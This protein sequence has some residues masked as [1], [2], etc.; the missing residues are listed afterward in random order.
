MPTA[1]PLRIAYLEDEAQNAETVGAWL[2]EAGYAVD[3]F[4]RGADCARAVERS[5]YDACLL[6]WMVPDMSGPE[7]LARIRLQLKERPPPVIFLTGRDSEEDLVAMLAAGADDYI[8]KPASRAVLLARVS[9]VLR[10]SGVALETRR[11]VW[12]ELELDFGLRRIFFQG[13]HIVLTERETDLALY[14]LQNTGRLLTRAHLLQTVWAH[15]AEVESR[16][17]DMHAST[18]RRKLH[19]SPQHGWQLVSIYGQGYRL[20]WLGATP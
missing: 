13:Q 14:L 1:L 9:A 8:V 20:E 10:R 18:L 2:R 7:V 17:V 15:S 5:L 19:L 16:K 3:C 4:T 11:R 6:D 12:G